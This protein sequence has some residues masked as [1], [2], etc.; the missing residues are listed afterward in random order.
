MLI[1]VSWWL[2]NWKLNQSTLT[3]HSY[4]NISINMLNWLIEI[5]IN[6]LNLWIYSNISILK[7]AKKICLIWSNRWWNE[8]HKT[9]NRSVFDT[10]GVHS[11]RRIRH[12]VS[13]VLLRNVVIFAMEFISVRSLWPRVNYKKKYETTFLGNAV[14]LRDLETKSFNK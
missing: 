9:E 13:P 4:I 10:H 11:G 2:I 8:D 7:L 5:N 3:Y 6:I 1:R 12:L 14:G